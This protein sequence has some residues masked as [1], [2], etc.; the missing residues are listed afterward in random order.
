MLVSMTAFWVVIQQLLDVVQPDCLVEIG[1]DQGECTQ[2]LCR[3]ASARQGH[4][5]VIETHPTEKL[6]KIVDQYEFARLHV[7]LSLEILPSLQEKVDCFIVDGDHN[8]YTVS[9]EL[10]LIAKHNTPELILLHDVC[11]PW[12]RR[13]IYYD[14][15]TIPQE[16]RRDPVLDPDAGI[17]PG[18]P[19]ISHEKGFHSKGQF[20]FAK[21]EGGSQNG[22]MSAVQ[23]FLNENPGYEL[24]TIECVFG[25]GIL[26]PKSSP[27]YAKLVA[28][29]APYVG[30]PLIKL[31][32]QD[33]LRTFV[34]SFHK[35]PSKANPTKLSGLFRFFKETFAKKPSVTPALPSAQQTQP[36]ISVVIVVYNMQR[37]ALRTLRS[38]A[39]AYQGLSSELYEVIVVENGSN[40]PL[41]KQQVQAFGPNF[42][43]FLLRDAHPSPVR[44]LN[45]GVKQAKGKMVGLMIDGAHLV[46]P[47]VLKYALRAFKAYKNPVVGML[48]LHLG[49]Q[50]QRLA[51]RN[52]YS[53]DVEDALLQQIDWPNNGYQLFG[54][55]ALTGVNTK[56]WFSPMLES[57]CIFMLRRT[58][59][60]MGGF[61]ERFDAPGGGLANLDFYERLCAHP[62]LELI[63]LLGEGS[64]HQIH[65]GVA[66][67]N[68]NEQ[69]FEANLAQWKEQYKAIRGKDFQGN[70]RKPEYWGSLA[71]A[72]TPLLQHSI[73][74]FINSKA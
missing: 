39:A 5:H 3:W 6:K 42:R 22:V 54:I 56:G 33:R 7:G 10:K 59:Q 8:Y 70:T 63:T 16:Y 52:G 36:L 55:S 1:G 51:I 26:V 38:F 48:A 60:Q 13:D 58:Y 65:G 41:S 46:T 14:L 45:F 11:W 40:Q 73:Q 21:T 43:Y 50:I 17:L 25:L 23:D 53:E 49:G 71:P 24:F 31:L 62:E 67:N 18:Q 15:E 30:N 12:G 34:D 47:G 19:G 69:S 57:N 68:A 72:A 44:A 28:I 4:V 2:K 66:T 37:V 9:N 27:Y 29:L 64:F 61:D 32:E 20:A 35:T 74:H